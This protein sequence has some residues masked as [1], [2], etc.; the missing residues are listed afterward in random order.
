GRGLTEQLI[1]G[2]SDKQRMRGVLIGEPSLEIEDRN[3]IIRVGDDLSIEAEVFLVA[4]ALGDVKKRD[5]HTD[6]SSSDSDRVAKALDRKTCSVL[7]P[8][9]IAGDGVGPPACQASMDGT[10]FLGIG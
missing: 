1:V 4:L 2:I 3:G 5:R 8:I 9:H 10:G 6:Q 7:T